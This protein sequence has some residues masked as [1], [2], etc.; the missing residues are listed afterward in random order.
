MT[1]LRELLHDA[2]PTAPEF[3]DE[4][5]V[6][7]IARRQRRRR[8]IVLGGLATTSVVVVAIAIGVGSTRHSAPNVD[9]VGPATTAPT[10]MVTTPAGYQALAVMPP[11]PPSAVQTMSLPSD[12]GGDAVAGPGNTLWAPGCSDGAP[13][14]GASYIDV[15]TGV[16][17]Q[18]PGTPADT[19]VTQVAV[20]AGGV[21][22]L[23]NGYTGAPFH[24]TRLDPTT[25]QRRWTVAV[26]D[27][28]VQGDPK[29]RLAF[30]AGALWFSDGTHPVVEFSPT[31]GRV[32]ASI[33]VPDYVENTG[34]ATFAFNAAGVWVVGGTSGTAVMHIDPTTKRLSVVHTFA[35]GFSQS[36]AADDRY[37]WTTHFTGRLDL[38]RIDTADRDRAIN[39]RIPTYRVASGDGQTWFLGYE[40]SGT[41]DNPAND[42]GTLGRIDPDTGRVIAVTDLPVGALDTIS[43][44]VH[45]GKAYVLDATA[46]TL[47]TVTP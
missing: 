42:H 10:P 5:V 39:V 4:I 28:S 20:G 14:A 32:L 47:T 45:R 44:I 38:A 16:V 24:V 18:L 29:A 25:G 15:S 31:D 1:D 19:A 26:P 7:T 41:T 8:A 9:S 3:D 12:F 13:C 27:T 40:P 46:H 2:A 33:P 17:R 23:S 11:L 43:L 6:R 22:V 34:D 36:L 37:I 35:G 21:F 30:G